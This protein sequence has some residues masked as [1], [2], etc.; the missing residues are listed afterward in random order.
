MSL[1]FND[2]DGVRIDE[3]L[4]LDAITVH[5]FT[6]GEERELQEGALYDWAINYYR[7]NY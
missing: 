3:D 1:F 6:N 5:Y 2:S 4:D 7:E